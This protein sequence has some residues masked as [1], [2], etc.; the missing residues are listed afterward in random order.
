MPR[1]K[2]AIKRAKDKYEKNNV[3]R[4][5]LKLSRVDADLIEFLDGKENINGYL[6]SLIRN[7]KE[8]GGV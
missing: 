4:F 8:K 2:E 3:R 1:S 6:K 7:D 5:T